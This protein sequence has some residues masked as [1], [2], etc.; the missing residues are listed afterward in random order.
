MNSSLNSVV[1]E[2]LVPRTPLY[3]SS[4]APAAGSERQMVDCPALYFSPTEVGRV[5]GIEDRSVNL[6]QSVA[7]INSEL[8]DLLVVVRVGVVV[9]AVRPQPELGVGVEGVTEDRDGVQGHHEVPDVGHLGLA[10][11]F[12]PT[13]G[14]VAGVVAHAGLGPVEVPVPVGVDSVA[15]ALW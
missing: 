12:R 13:E 1:N 5:D 4:E 15:L 10:E 9:V 11:G 7:R 3:Q 6:K 2:N 8:P 14:L